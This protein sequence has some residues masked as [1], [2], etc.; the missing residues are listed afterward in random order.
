MG[1]KSSTSHKR[2]SL[3]PVV[4][5]IDNVSSRSS[6]LTLQYSCLRDIGG[7]EG[8]SMRPH[9]P[10]FAMNSG[11]KVVT[12]VGCEISCCW[13]CCDNCGEMTVAGLGTVLTI[14]SSGHRKTSISPCDDLMWIWSCEMSMVHDENQRSLNCAY[15]VIIFVTLGWPRLFIGFGTWSV[16]SGG[17]LTAIIAWSRYAATERKSWYVT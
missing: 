13:D 15:D 4:D 6:S 7:L 1:P 8:G 2:A 12:G 5:S 17:A 3:I 10:L 16:A 11:G 9:A 14:G